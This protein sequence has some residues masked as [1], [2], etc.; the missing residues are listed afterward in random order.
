MRGKAVVAAAVGTAAAVCLAGC[1]GSGTS[2]AVSSTAG[3][4]SSASSSGATG[5]AAVCGAADDLQESLTAMQEVDVVNQGT[6]ALRQSFSD[7]QTAFSEFTDV[8]RAQYAD[9]VQKVKDDA[10]A[11]RTA[12]DAAQSNPTAES[13]GAVATA[14]RVLG[15][16]AQALVAEAKSSC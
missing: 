7:V 3:S 13:A 1:G 8:A 9:A 16:D 12:M 5:S 15:Q 11:V 14:A 10:A 2:T 4:S 6:D